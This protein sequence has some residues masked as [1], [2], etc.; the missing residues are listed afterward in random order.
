MNEVLSQLWRRTL[1]ARE[2]TE[3]LVR[4]VQCHTIE[5]QQNMVSGRQLL[6]EA[7]ECLAKYNV[8]PIDLPPV[9]KRAGKDGTKLPY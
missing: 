8:N 9:E 2:S 4:I 7:R 3:A 1:D 6:N 5:C